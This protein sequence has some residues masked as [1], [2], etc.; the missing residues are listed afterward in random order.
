MRRNL[1]KS[2]STKQERIVHEVL[3]EL[4]I[5]FKHRWTIEGREVDFLLFDKICLEINGHE[6]D[7][8]KNQI[9][10]DQGYTPLHL[11]NDEVTKETVT[12]LIKQLI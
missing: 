5:P 4:H 1:L 6:Q 9:L 3:K 2:H 11:H 10:A 12:T 8:A 7:T